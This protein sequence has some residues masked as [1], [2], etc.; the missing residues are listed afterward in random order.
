M[1]T[2]ELLNQQNHKITEL[3]NVLEN[4]LSDRSLCGY[5]VT[6]ELFYRYIEEV[7]SH[8][9]IIDNNLYSRLLTHKEQR[10]RNT[11]D[12]FMGGSKEVKRIFSAY[13]KKWCQ[14]KSKE[15]VIKEYDRFVT[16]TNEMF[17]LVLNRIQAETEHLYPLIRQATGDYQ[18]A[19]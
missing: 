7:K 9:E 1:I 11:V 19:A 14:M 18:H 16:E 15:L 10:V 6:C 12:R 3:T 5:E 4:L 13:V 17:E 2:Y 8:L